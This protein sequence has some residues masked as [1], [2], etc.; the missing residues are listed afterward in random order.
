MTPA[1]SAAPAAGTRPLASAARRLPSVPY[2]AITAWALSFALVLYLALRSGGF[3]AVVRDQVGIL[4]WWAV[5]LVA[6]AGLTPRLTQ[7][8]WLALALLGAFAVWTALGI[9][10]SE[11][12][13]R[14]LAETG[15]LSC[16][17]GV[18]AL[19]LILQTRAG[20]R[21]VLNG[22]ATAIGLVT[23]L[24]VLSRLHPQ[25]FPQNAQ[26]EFLPTQAKRLSYPLNYWNALAGFMAMG[27]VLLLATAATARTR[28]GQ[29]I[30]AAA[31]PLTGLGVYL[32]ISR[33]GAIVIV[34]G[35]A[36][37][38]LLTHDRL[39]RLATLA[40]T[41][42]AAAIL[43]VAADQ[44]PALQTG[45]DTATARAQ[46]SDLIVLALLVCAGTGLIHVAIELLARHTW[47]PRYLRIGRR[48]ATF[49]T[50]IA[51]AA[52]LAAFFGSSLNN[53]AADRWHE[54]KQPPAV[55]GQPSYNNVFDRLQ[56]S[57]GQG[58]WQYWEVAADAYHDQPTT[59][60]GAGSFEFYWAR[61]ASIGGSITDAHSLYVQTLAE[62]G[63]IGLAL[64]LG[65]VALTVLGG[66]ARALRT[67]QGTERVLLAGATAAVTVFWLQAA[68]EWTWQIAVMPVALLFCTAVIVGHRD[69]HTT[70]ARLPARTLTTAAAIAAFLP[71]ALGLT[72]LVQVRES[73]QA[74]RDNNPGLALDAARRAEAV[75]GTSTTA[76]LQQALVL[77]RLNRID[78][79]TA[80]A[81][82][83]TRQEPTNWR[84]WLVR[85]RLELRLGA[86][87]D[88]LASFRKA[89]RLNP[90]SPLFQG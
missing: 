81:V 22:V 63:W 75:A 7:K 26:H 19:A 41:G 23:L 48:T 2:D 36:V 43:I 31:V 69:P 80:A 14:T 71:I 38:A 58:R 55:A 67:K 87:R 85:S 56:S 47:R 70:P 32:A 88:A 37:Y 11:S 28:A 6:V 59:G 86:D 5:L 57:A 29:A 61:H 74:V 54:F 52:A 42:G 51:T 18:L 79:A 30:A 12:A 46:G 44:R 72:T 65:L 73:Q 24:A 50:A 9:P 49:T 27:T 77:E 62:T 60:I 3:D 21:H 66:A 10:D 17:V 15:R 89:R 83:A 53:Q 84:T 1:T 8:G 13:E 68:I 16:Y 33:S 82:K 4:V 78:E 64:L 35:L 45:V 40:T 20:S 39:A 34:V 25:L 90:R 76:L